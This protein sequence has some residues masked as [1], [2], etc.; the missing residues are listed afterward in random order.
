MSIEQRHGT[1]I[2][3]KRDTKGKPLAGQTSLL[4]VNDATP[5]VVKAQFDNIETGYGY[6]WHEFSADEFE[7]DPK[8][9]WDDQ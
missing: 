1:Y 2:G 3:S 6:G 8:V 5:S 4:L 9:D 7:L